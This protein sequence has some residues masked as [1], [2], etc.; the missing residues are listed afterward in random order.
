MPFRCDDDIKICPGK[1][2]RQI[3]D[4]ALNTTLFKRI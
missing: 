2:I 3:R 4:N 1:L